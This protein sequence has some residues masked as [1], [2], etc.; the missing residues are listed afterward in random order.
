L[1]YKQRTLRSEVECTGIGLHTGSK[2]GLKLKPAPPNTGIR[3]IRKDLPGQPEIAAKN[4]N[5]VETNLSTSI[6]RNGCGVSTVE[7]LMAALFGLGIDNARVEVT[8]PE[9]P[10][11]DGSS[12]PFVFLIKTAGIREQNEPKR[13]LVIRKRFRVEDGNR[14][15]T[16]HPSRALKITYTIDFNH[17]LLK[18]QTYVLKFSGGGFIRDISRARTFGFLKDIQ[19]LRDNG[20]AMG[21][22]LDNAIV[23][24]DFRV[25]NEDGL[26]YED[27]FVRHKILD[28][29][30][31]LALLG[32]PVIGHFVVEKSGHYLNQVMLRELIQSE[33]HWRVCSFKDQEEAAAENRLRLPA[34]GVLEP[35]VA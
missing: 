11:M 32:S 1:D 28:F 29:L 12:A 5:V 9:V 18:D 13:F 6:G 34:F 26:R 33:K 3:F 17:P 15:I 21:G 20:L 23:I 14:S 22:S 31:D 7:H 30:G 27:E 2:V 8:G 24:D 19:L 4:G 35:G 25:L 16:V 10:I